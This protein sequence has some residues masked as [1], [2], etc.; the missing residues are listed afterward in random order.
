MTLHTEVLSETQRQII[1]TLGPLASSC[2]FYLGGD[3]AVALYY[4]HRRSVDF[5][6]FAR[7]KFADPMALAKQMEEAGLR[8]DSMQ[9]APGTLHGIA[10]GVRVSFFD[11]PYPEMGVP[12][13]WPD[14]AFEMASLDDL[15]CMKLAAVAQR[16]SRKDFVDL[17]IIALRH[18]PIQEIIGLYQRRYHTDDIAHVLVGLTYFDDAEEE[19]SLEM[20]SAIG[21]DEVKREFLLWAKSLAG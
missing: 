12:T 14:L 4:G 16:G 10:E 6:W 15:A 18:K 1:P 7:E 9:V 3:T 2:G 17:H 21:W 5:D 13:P 20:L 8:L 11:Y 19:P